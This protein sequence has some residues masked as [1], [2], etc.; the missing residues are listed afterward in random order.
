[1]RCT[2]HSLFPIPTIA[3]LEQIY[4]NYAEQGD[5][6]NV[7][8]SRLQHIYPGKIALI[9]KHVSGGNQILDIGAGLGGFAAL[10]RKNGFAVT[11]VEFEK[12]QCIL[13]KQL[14]D[15]DLICS[16]FEEF[17]K[18]SKTT[19]DVIHL[20]HVLEHL[21]N[22]KEVLVNARAILK[23]NGKL[24]LEVPN[25]F[26]VLKNEVYSRLGRLRFKKPYNPYHHLYFFSPYTLKI[27]LRASGFRILEYNEV[28]EGSNRTLKNRINHAVSRVFK[29][30][31]SSRIEVV[32]SR[33]D[34]F[35][36]F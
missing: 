5:R 10:A 12:Q 30:G 3:E 21:R 9:A 32:A 19:Y 29:M 26:F 13:A 16:S 4:S 1:M 20:H 15:V 7:E 28:H 31:I 18:T 27:M 23:E 17:F 34:S 11:G 14:F 6:I 35:R 8:R 25:Q 22:P 24:I 36:V 33:I 2:L